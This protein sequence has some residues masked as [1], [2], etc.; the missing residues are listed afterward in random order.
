MCALIG[1][2]MRPLIQ[3]LDSS[4]PQ[5]LAYCAKLNSNFGMLFM[6][7]VH[8]IFKFLWELYCHCYK[9]AVLLQQ[10]YT[11]EERLDISL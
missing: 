9:E 1:S 11:S 2:C 4:C 7:Y 5:N 6:S 10:F 3:V 8:V